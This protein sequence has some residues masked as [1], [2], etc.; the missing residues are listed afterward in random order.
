MS[1]SMFS[2]MSGTTLDV[3]YALFHFTP[4][5]ILARQAAKF[6]DKIA[7]LRKNMMTILVADDSKG[8]GLQL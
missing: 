2:A 3:V 6:L 8:V 5:G 4:S 7:L 1:F